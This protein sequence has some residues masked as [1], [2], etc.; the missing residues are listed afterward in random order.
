MFRIISSKLCDNFRDRLALGGIL[1]LPVSANDNNAQRV[2]EF[3][4]FPE[5][6]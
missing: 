5:A 6:N 4:T 3:A 1:Y 2:K